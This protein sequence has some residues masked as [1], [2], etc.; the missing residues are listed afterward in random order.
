MTRAC[1]NCILFN[2]KPNFRLEDCLQSVLYPGHRL[3]EAAEEQR[4][5]HVARQR[6]RERERILAW[7][8]HAAG[9]VKYRDLVGE[10]LLFTF[11][12]Y[13]IKL[14]NIVIFFL[15]LSNCLNLLQYFYLNQ[16]HIFFSL[17]FTYLLS[18]KVILKIIYYLILFIDFY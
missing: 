3:V 10:D 11:M 14:C 5:G 16:I 12:I 15:W 8:S 9:E 17:W 13:I 1:L 6:E 18:I 4:C 2:I 7:R